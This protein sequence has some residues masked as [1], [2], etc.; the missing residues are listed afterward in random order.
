MKYKLRDPKDIGNVLM[1]GVPS[2]GK[3]AL[4]RNSRFK[5]KRALK[6]FYLMD[7]VCG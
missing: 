4:P 2:T 1:E 3:K 7:S 5:G 6:I